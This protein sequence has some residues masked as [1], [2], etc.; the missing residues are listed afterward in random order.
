MVV[1]SKQRFCGHERQK[2]GGCLPAAALTKGPDCCGETR[3]S[4]ASLAR[5]GISGEEPT[6]CLLVTD[7]LFKK[8]ATKRQPSPSDL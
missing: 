7:V 5:L 3:V 4:V 2:V 1:V 8:F 6:C